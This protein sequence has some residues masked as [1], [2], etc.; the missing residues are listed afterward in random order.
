MV[1]SSSNNE[2]DAAMLRPLNVTMTLERKNNNKTSVVRNNNNNRK[3]TNTTTTKNIKPKKLTKKENNKPVLLLDDDGDPSF[4]I[5]LLLKD[6]NDILNEWIAYH[7]HAWNLRHLIVAI[8]PKSHTSPS[9]LFQN[10][11]DQFDD[12]QVDEWHDKNYMPD[13]FLQGKFDQV[14]SYLPVFIQENISASIWHTTDEKQTLTKDQLSKDL[15]MINNHRFRQV[16]FGS[17]CMET[18]RNNNTNQEEGGKRWV[19]HIDT[20][21]YMVINP[22]LRARPNA[23]K[24][25]TLPSVPHGGSMM[26]FLEQ[27]LIHYPKR[28]SRTC[29]MMPSLLFGAIEDDDKDPPVVNNR[30]IIPKGWNGTKFETLRWKHH[31][32]WTD[33]ANGMQKAVVDVSELSEN[34]A[35]FQD[36]RIKSVHQPLEHPDCRRMILKPEVDAVRLFPLT[37]NHYVGSFQRYISRQDLR[38]NLQI[39]QKKANVNGGVDRDGWMDGWLESFVNEHGV[40]RVS[41]VLGEYRVD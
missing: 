32:N 17:H 9:A 18:L 11:R 5:C 34:H 35:I 40:E 25:V 2:K 13:Y 15:I 14:P 22:Q 27:M 31:A 20:D 6:D 29:V 28:L 24:G 23:V 39:Y 36:H 4:S 41:H 30:T 38:R 3:S 8:D 16:T 19:A 21:E 37:I 1:G 7:Y 12:L 26:R 33:I 10:W